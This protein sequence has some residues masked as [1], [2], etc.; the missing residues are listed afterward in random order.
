[1]L[2]NILRN[3]NKPQAIA[4]VLGG[5]LVGLILARFLIISPLA[6][7]VAFAS[8]IIL[9]IT[10]LIRK[11]EYLLIGWIVLTS[12]IWFV[13]TRVLPPHYYPYAG[14]AIFWGILFCIIVAWAMDNILT[15]KGFVPFDHVGLKSTVFL[16]LIWFSISVGTSL[17]FFESA[18]KL[19][20]IITALVVSYM[21]YD[22]FSRDEKNM[23][24]ILSA[25]FF[26]VLII[27]F[28]AVVTAVHA[29]LSGNPIYKT[30]S[31]WFIN[32]NTLGSLLF[33]CLPICIVVALDIFSKRW[34]SLLLIAT[35]L[36][37]LF[38][39]FHR[40]SWL[41]ALVSLFFLLSKSRM[42]TPIL[43]GAVVILFTG[44]LLFPVFG[45]ATY[46]YA[47]GERYSGRTE[48][49]GAAWQ[50]ACDFPLFGAG[51]GESVRVMSKYIDTP[52]LRNQDTHSVYL[53]NA[54]ELGF[55][56]VIILVAVFAG[57]FGA[58]AKIEKKLRSDYLRR[59][60]RVA[61][62]TFWGLLVHGIFE[63]GFFMTPF[64]GAEF[65]VMLP[66]IVLALPFAAKKLDDGK[67]VNRQQ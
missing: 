45:G 29:I 23:R 4:L 1:M 52:W 31:L 46:D 19:V 61:A 35:I 55:G 48:I 37:G 11:I 6:G 30:I 14:R 7:L 2:P 49:W 33:L 44:A 36:L 39:S 20:H 12:V 50:T 56:S 28:G 57:F 53:R 59:I 18:K 40:S 62:A 32:P 67:I 65:H 51:P 43:A 5:L 34:L 63:N 66:Y 42:K 21:F 47:T 13:L 58:S 26:I 54:A 24:R 60:N 16:F 25:V 27:S 10:I 17:H 22:F 41:A 38:F 9:V 64:V 3:I 15:R 8:A